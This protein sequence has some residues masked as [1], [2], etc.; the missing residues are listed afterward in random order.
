MD[1][2]NE[3]KS[4]TFGCPK[5]D[6]FAAIA[7]IGLLRGIADEELDPALDLGEV[8]ELCFR[9]QV[10]EETGRVW[11][12][13]YDEKRWRAAM[14]RFTARDAA[15]CWRELV[16]HWR[17]LMGRLESQRAHEALLEPR[18][19]LQV[20][21]QYMNDESASKAYQALA[22]ILLER[23]TELDSVA[24]EWWLN[25]G[26]TETHSSRSGW[27]WPLRIGF[28]ADKESRSLRAA[29]LDRERSWYEDLVDAYVLTGGVETCDLLVSPLPLSETLEAVRR[30]R[31]R[32]TAV[33]L[34]GRELESSEREFVQVAELRAAA[35]ASVLMASVAPPEARADL[36]MRLFE[37]LSHNEPLDSAVCL[38]ARGLAPAPLVISQHVTADSVRISS[39]GD[40]AARLLT[41]RGVAEE[42]A[43][44]VNN[45]P[46]MVFLSESGDATEIAR[47]TRHLDDR[48]DFTEARY[49]QA[50]TYHAG[51]LDE[52]ARRPASSFVAGRWHLVEAF[53]GPW[54]RSDTAASSE[55][56][57]EDQVQYRWDQAELTIA[58]T[59]R[60]CEVVALPYRKRRRFFEKDQMAVT[61][62]GAGETARCLIGIQ[63]IGRSRSALFALRPE[64]AGRVD[65][66]LLVAHNNRILQTAL[67]S[68]E[69]HRPDEIVVEPGEGE[70]RFVPLVVEGV[71]R[72]DLVELGERGTSDVAFMINRIGDGLPTLTSLSDAGVKIGDFSG[73]AQAA[74]N[75][76]KEL[77]TMVES[78]KDFGEAG[79]EALRE[80]LVHLALEGTRLYRRLVHDEG[81]EGELGEPHSRIQLVAADADSWV[82][83][84]FVYDGDAPEDSALLCPNHKK[85]L[86]G[87]SCQGVR[88]EHRDSEDYV[89]PM[90]FWG[91]N[92]VIERHMFDPKN[93]PDSDRAVVDASLT[94][95]PRIRRPENALFAHHEKAGEFTAGKQELEEVEQTLDCVASS[96]VDRVDTW[97][98]WV[99]SIK[100][101]EPGLLVVLP[102]TELV[103][104]GTELRIAD[105]S[106]P[107]LHRLVDARVIKKHVGVS[108]PKIVFLLGCETSD[109]KTAYA[110]FPSAF[111]SAGASIIIAT[112]TSVLGRHA[113]PVAR[114]LMEKLDEYWSEST[115]PATVGTALA[116][117]RRSL[118]AA[119]L[120][121]G[122]V[123]VAYGDA[124]WVI[125]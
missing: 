117:V 37:E 52:M 96:G 25:T 98:N 32:A 73:A 84:E 86:S 14:D 43:A 53:V 80:M 42:A 95:R 1:L 66:R 68:A 77:E 94:L 46:G 70:P 112:L 99:E 104:G 110:S 13:G 17:W 124:D 7:A 44:L 106:D 45:I 82:P 81:L 114:Q 4:W 101:R 8:A 55:A 119:G 90:R 10:S 67:L 121:F 16:P 41:R 64:Q 125:G 89:C 109:V 60:G 57:P 24:F 92:R 47:W 40:R 18:L 33:L 61:A 113:T 72:V 36:V 105:G 20:I 27:H 2:V 50:E 62:D 74:D 26:A 102:H 116:E 69:V 103:A 49:L 23:S 3:L 48:S 120:P 31:A 78:P 87:G 71:T 21:A 56:F 115:D 111:R 28:P 88:C 9:R 19:R 118:V 12:G 51:A 75:L 58:L 22:Q 85:A 34:L 91:L 76:R 29:V 6:E 63:P 79:S 97:P 11:W 38:A 65:A 122:M 15:K 93:R 100:T 83:L 30:A 108:R 39:W 123:L 54:R 107:Q 35:Q 5:A 59:A